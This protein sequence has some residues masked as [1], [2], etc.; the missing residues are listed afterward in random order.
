MAQATSAAWNFEVRGQE[1]IEPQVQRQHD[2]IRAASKQ[3]DALFEL[4]R[5]A[6]AGQGDSA[7]IRDRCPG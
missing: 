5:G 6:T 4:I 7:Q 2:R 1:R 3:F